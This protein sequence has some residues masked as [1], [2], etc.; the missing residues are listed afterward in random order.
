MIPF[1]L[2]QDAS[3]QQVVAAVSLAVI[4]WMGVFVV[5][6]CRRKCPRRVRR[7]KVGSE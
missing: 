3:V 2:V 4:V 7:Q 5:V 1:D 6:G